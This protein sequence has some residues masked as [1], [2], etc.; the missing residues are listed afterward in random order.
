M[1]IFRFAGN[2]RHINIICWPL[3]QTELRGNDVNAN[4]INEKQMAFLYWH[5]VFIF[6]QAKLDEIQSKFQT[7]AMD[8][9]TY[10]DLDMNTASENYDFN[11]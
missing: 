1:E 9:M 4:K 7:L 6:S 10:G 11:N 2:T 5:I 8:F 3:T